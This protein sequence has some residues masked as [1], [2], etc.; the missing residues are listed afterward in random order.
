MTMQVAVPR[1]ALGRSVYGMCAVNPS[2][3][4]RIFGQQALKLVVD[5]IR[6]HSGKLLEIVN[7]N[8]EN[9]QYVVA[10]ELSNLGVLRVVLDSIKKLK[11]DLGEV[12][13][14]R[15]GAEIEI[16]LSGLVQSVLQTVE[17]QAEEEG[18]FLAQVRGE[19]TVPLAGI[20]VPF[21][22]S[23]LLNGVV[24]FRQMLRAKLDPKY[25]NIGLLIGKYIPNLTAAPFDVSKEY[26]RLVYDLTRS[27]QLSRILSGWSCEAAS[28]EAGK[29]ELGYA[30]L[31]ELLA[32]QFAS[33]VRWIETQDVLF[34]EFRVERLIEVGPSPVLC[35]M[36]ARTLKVKYEAFDDALTHRRV[37]LVTTKHRREIYYEFEDAFSKPAEASAEGVTR[38]AAAASVPV[39]ALQA[40]AVEPP[41]PAASV[42]CVFHLTSVFLSFGAVSKHVPDHQKKKKKKKTNSDEPVQ[43]KEILLALVASKLKKPLSE[44][45]PSKSIKDLVG[46]KSTLQNEILGDLAAEF[47]NVL[48]DKAEELPLGDVAVALQET[49][50]G[51]LGKTSSGNV[52]KMISGKMPAGFGM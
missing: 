10:G 3:M 32:H 47:G 38:S 35:G 43:A 21:H 51:S 22:S 49:H 29:Q 13:E 11:V 41:R 25:I 36:A 12:A 1:D 42:T 2:R 44:I 50:S 30:I 33:P 9:I 52:N 34:R 37:Q 15:S 45:A 40:L 8:V 6:R 26:A 24:P 48:S 14:E 17:R 27:D 18:G 4:G 39:P 20:D 5:V 16:G 7:Y 19:A 28:T 31:L 23:F 46:G